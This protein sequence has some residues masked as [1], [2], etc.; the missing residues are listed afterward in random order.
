MGLILASGSPRRLELLKLIT[1]DFTVIPADCE[2]HLDNSLSPHEAVKALACQ[3]AEFVSERY[4]EQT[5]IGADTTVF[6]GNMSLGKPK[7]AAD[8]KLMLNTLSGKIH[9]VITAVAVAKGGKILKAFSEETQVEFYPLSEKETDEY[10]KSGEPMDKAGAYG[11]QGKGALLIKRINGDYY[12]VMG[13]PVAR[14][15]RELLI[16]YSFIF[17]YSKR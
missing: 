2:E 11:I 15:A 4:P 12:N 10:I 9:S 3:K 1:E 5:V 8:A 7:D 13:L 17:T 14:L 6:C 16:N